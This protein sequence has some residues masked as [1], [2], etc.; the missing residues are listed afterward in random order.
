[1]PILFVRENIKEYYNLGKFVDNYDEN[2]SLEA[3]TLV[4]PFSNPTE[5]M[6]NDSTNTTQG[7]III[8]FT[9]SF[10]V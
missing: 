3:L 7:L 4:L 6:Q 9:F 8:M 1:M 10:K 5:T 2:H